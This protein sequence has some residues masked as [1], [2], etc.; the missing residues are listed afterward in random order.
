MRRKHRACMQ[1]GSVYIARAWWCFRDT[2]DRSGRAPREEAAA[3]LPE[4]PASDSSP[5][6]SARPLALQCLL[7]FYGICSQDLICASGSE[8][9]LSE[10]HSKVASPRRKQTSI[11]SFCRSVLLA[12]NER[13]RVPLTTDPSRCPWWGRNKPGRKPRRCREI[14]QGDGV[15]RG[16]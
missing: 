5:T 12:Q 9:Y 4:T 8:S 14:T 6:S 11:T 16:G 15:G 13:G 3:W 10:Q 7:L 1:S 2:V